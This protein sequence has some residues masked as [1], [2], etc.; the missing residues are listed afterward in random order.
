MDKGINLMI[1][2][3]KIEIVDLINSYDLPMIIKRQVINEISLEINNVTENV[4][5]KE[6]Q[7]YQK[8]LEAQKEESKSKKG[9]K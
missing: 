6:R 3:F 5:Q 4:I 7:D 8:A 1:N 9:G 2:D